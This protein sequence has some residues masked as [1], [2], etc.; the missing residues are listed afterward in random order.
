MQFYMSDG[1]SAECLQVHDTK[2]S[3]VHLTRLFEYCQKVATFSFTLAEENLD[4]FRENHWM[5]MGFRKMRDLKII[6]FNLGNT[7]SISFWPILLEIVTY[8]PRFYIILK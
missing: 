2:I 5:K 6:A 7:L 1:K 4:A 3:L 8:V